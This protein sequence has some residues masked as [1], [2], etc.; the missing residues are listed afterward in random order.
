[1]VEWHTVAQDVN[2][3]A[4]VDLIAKSSRIQCAAGVEVGQR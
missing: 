4:I 2:N 3:A 1:M